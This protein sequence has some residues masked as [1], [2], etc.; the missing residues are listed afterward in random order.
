[1]KTRQEMIYDFMLALAS[2]AEFFNAWNT[3]EIDNDSITYGHVVMDYAKQL[4]DQML[5]GL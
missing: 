1:M 4:A 2:N 3:T 5:K